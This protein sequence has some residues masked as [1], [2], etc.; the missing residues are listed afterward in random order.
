MVKENAVCDIGSKFLYQR[1]PLC[2][3]PFHTTA[4]IISEY[5]ATALN[6]SGNKKNNPN[7]S[8]SVLA[9]ANFTSVAGTPSAL[10]GQESPHSCVQALVGPRCE[11]DGE[12]VDPQV[13]VAAQG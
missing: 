9:L 4:P 6:C 10:Y 13:E 3:S 12:G 7:I 8:N 2:K 11:E 1:I 5:R